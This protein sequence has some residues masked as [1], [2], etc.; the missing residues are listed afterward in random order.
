MS[1]VTTGSSILKLMS[2]YKK[3]YVA[4]NITGACC[5]P[6]C[7]IGLACLAPAQ[8]IG[9]VLEQYDDVIYT[10]GGPTSLTVLADKIR[11]ER[12]IFRDAVTIINQLCDPTIIDSDITLLDVIIQI[13]PRIRHIINNSRCIGSTL[14]GIFNKNEKNNEYAS[15]IWNEYEKKGGNYTVI[16]YGL[17]EYLCQL[18]DP[19][20]QY[21]IN[22]VEKFNVDSALRTECL[23][24]K[25]I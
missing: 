10:Y 20:S 24:Y 12:V 22:F 21:V 3:T 23:Q 4:F 14:L 6:V 13:N 7:C 25:T 1:Q 16:I 15:L 11:N 9:H 5:L 18:H 8:V 19:T 2:T 17:I